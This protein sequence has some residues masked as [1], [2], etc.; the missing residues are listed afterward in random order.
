M[1]ASQKSSG[2]FHSESFL[3]RKKAP[4]NGSHTAVKQ[5]SFSLSLQTII[6]WPGMFCGKCVLQLS[7]KLS[8]IKFSG[9]NYYMSLWGHIKH[10][11]LMASDFCDSTHHDKFKFK[12]FRTKCIASIWNIFSESSDADDW[13]GI[14][15]G[16]KKGEKKKSMTHFIC[17]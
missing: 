17:S 6:S 1:L 7:E 13:L 14:G 9:A 4:D 10:F 2:S 15:A 16:G 8:K 11:M 12:H 3:R 5:K